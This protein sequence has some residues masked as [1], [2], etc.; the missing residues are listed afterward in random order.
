M[1]RKTGGG[2][3]G[4]KPPLTELSSHLVGGGIGVIAGN[5]VLSVHSL[6]VVGDVAPGAPAS[7]IEVLGVVARPGGKHN[8][9]MEVKVKW[10]YVRCG[11]NKYEDDW[12][13]GLFITRIE[14]AVG[15][16]RKLVARVANSNLSDYFDSQSFLHSH[17]ERH[18]VMNIVEPTLRFLPC[19]SS[20]PKALDRTRSNR[21]SA[22]RQGCFD[23]RET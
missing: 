4:R 3:R 19:L 6:G 12:L 18:S 23:D 15:I 8:D 5:C 1:I 16:Y 22:K 17:G 11:R 2:T 20:D 21:G 9:G 10:L 14:S 7:V 13:P